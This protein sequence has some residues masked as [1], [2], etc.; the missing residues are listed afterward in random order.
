M[1]SLW[2]C[3]VLCI[4]MWCKRGRKGNIG[5][6]RGGKS[7]NKTKIALVFIMCT[8]CKCSLVRCIYGSG[9]TNKQWWDL[10][11]LYSSVFLY[12]F[13]F[14]VDNFIKKKEMG[15]VYGRSPSASVLKQKPIIQTGQLQRTGRSQKGKHGPTG[16]IHKR[17]HIVRFSIL[18]KVYFFQLITK[19]ICFLNA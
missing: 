19:I 8:W 10:S 15:Q 12:F 2:I 13:F 16:P 7:G 1:V 3:N 17:W 9:I 14:S 5:L 11:P 6:L 18:L 4:F